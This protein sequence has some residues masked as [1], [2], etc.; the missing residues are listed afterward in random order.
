MNFLVI[1]LNK[2]EY[3]E[4]IT[5]LLAEAGIGG[6][7]IINSEC[8]GHYL[9]YEVPIFAGL[10]QLVGEG[11]AT[12]KT[13]LAALDSDKVFIKFKELLVE[14]DIDFTKPGVGAIVVIPA[15]EVIKSKEESE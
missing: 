4:K 14:E 7:T 3:F 5:S 13:I 8:I 2:E 12:N 15:N 9:A 6:A 11:K 1:I 10:R